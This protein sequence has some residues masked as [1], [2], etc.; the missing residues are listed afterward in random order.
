MP[1][2]LL[3]ELPEFLRPVEA[4]APVQADADFLA[5][6]YASTRLDL[7]STTA[8][9]AFVASLIAMQQRLQG[10][11]YRQAFPDAE[12]LLLEQAGA[13]CGRIVVDA[14]AGALRLVDIAL[15]PQLRGQGLGRHILLALQR[16]AAR[17]RLPMTLA[18]HHANPRARRLYL[19]LGFRPHS[20]DALSEQMLWN[21]E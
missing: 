20:R 12:Y 19:A 9:P 5:R 21:N 17:H 4:R 10:A 15:L 8:D 13:P 1:L 11:G 2:A 14:G 6:L 16:C 18:V 3:R 7:H